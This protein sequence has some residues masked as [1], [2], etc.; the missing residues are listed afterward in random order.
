MIGEERDSSAHGRYAE[1]TAGAR[2]ETGRAVIGENRGR[3]GNA[4]STRR[5]VARGMAR[6]T[7]S[8]N[9]GPTRK[10]A[11]ETYNARVIPT[12]PGMASC[13]TSARERGDSWGPR[14]AQRLRSRHVSA[15]G[16]GGSAGF[17]SADGSWRLNLIL[18]AFLAKMSYFSTKQIK[19]N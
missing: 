6:R 4:G 19:L 1:E 11:E 9:A 8:W 16:R 13:A 5:R 7:H 14:L 18:I 10:R 17:D 15:R 12:R 2:V 3:T